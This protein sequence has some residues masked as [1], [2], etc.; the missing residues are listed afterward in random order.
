MPQAL[1]RTVERFFKQKEGSKPHVSRLLVVPKKHVGVEV[2]VG[3][4]VLVEECGLAARDA[5]GYDGDKAASRIN[6]V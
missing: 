6:K 1:L 5:A 3:V 2:P 4:D